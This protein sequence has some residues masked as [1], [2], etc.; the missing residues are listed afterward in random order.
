MCRLNS[1]WQHARQSSGA[2]IGACLRISGEASSSWLAASSA[3]ACR[4]AS[5][6][7]VCCAAAALVDSSVRSASA[8]TWASKLLSALVTCWLSRCA[9]SELHR[10]SMRELVHGR[11]PVRHQCL[12]VRL[13]YGMCI[14]GPAACLDHACSVHTA[15]GQKLLRKVFRTQ[16]SLLNA[17]LRCPRLVSCPGRPRMFP[18]EH[19]KIQALAREP[20][21]ASRRTCSIA[22]RRRW[23][24]ARPQIAGPPAS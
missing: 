15:A 13:G 22:R 14:A 11:Q 2:R 23:R 19:A 21:I 9:S 17:T 4:S 7:T 12:T 24:C 1:S 18:A 16:P 5:A 6:C 3:V 20:D 10:T 8:L